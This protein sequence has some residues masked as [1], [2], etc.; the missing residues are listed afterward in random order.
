MPSKWLLHDK[1]L[2][3]FRYIQT[4]VSSTLPLIMREVIS[5]QLD[6]QLTSTSV[7]SSPGYLTWRKDS[8]CFVTSDLQLFLIEPLSLTCIP[9]TP[10]CYIRAMWPPFDGKIPYKLPTLFP[11]IQITQKST[12]EMTGVQSGESPWVTTSRRAILES[13]QIHIEFCVHKK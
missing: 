9:Q 2:F 1:Q 7:S 13:G 6:A 10:W 11:S 5:R 3:P 12:H 8:F 4:A